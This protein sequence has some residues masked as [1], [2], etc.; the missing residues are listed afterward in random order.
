MDGRPGPWQRLIFGVFCASV[1]LFFLGLTFT[2]ARSVADPYAPPAEGPV[3]PATPEGQPVCP[4]S[5]LGPFE[6]EDV[7]AGET[8]LLRVEL[9]E[10]CAAL[11]ARLDRL[12]ERSWWVVAEAVRAS[13]QRSITNERLSDIEAAICST[14]CAVEV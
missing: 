9:G 6:G 12:R 14:P 2:V 4:S 10:V 11:S 8:R 3:E 1:L 13:E 5:E 7:A